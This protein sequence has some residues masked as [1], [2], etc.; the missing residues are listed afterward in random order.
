VARLVKIAASGVVG[1][2][3]S[4]SVLPRDAPCGIRRMMID[5]QNLGAGK[6]RFESAS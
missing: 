5:E 4:R 2:Y 3:D 1:S 6:Q